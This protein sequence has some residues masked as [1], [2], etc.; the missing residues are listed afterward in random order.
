MS[1][2][3]P[4]S[5]WRRDRALV[6]P[7][8]KV[9]APQQIR[10]G[11]TVSLREGFMIP[12]LL[13]APAEE[14]RGA[15]VVLIASCAAR[16]LSVLLFFIVAAMPN[17]CMPVRLDAFVLSPS[18]C[19]L[20]NAVV[21]PIT[22]PNYGFL[23]YDNNLIQHDVLNHHD[24][25]APVGAAYNSRVTDL[26]TG[27]L[28][29][30]RL[31][32]YVHWVLPR[33]YRTGIAATSSAVGQQQEA[34][35]QQGFQPNKLTKDY[36]APDF[37]SAPNR[38][39]VIRR[40]EPGSTDNANSGIPEFQGWVLESDC[41]SSLEELSDDADLETD[42]S[43]FIQ[44]EATVAEQAEKFIGYREDA[45]TWFEG[46]PNP[47]TNKPPSRANL[48]L[49][50]SSNHLFAD[51]QPHNTNVFS[52]IDT[53]A[54]TTTDSKGNTVLQN[55]KWATASYY[56]LGWHAKDPSLPDIDPDPFNYQPTDNPVTFNDRMNACLMELAG[57]PGSNTVEDEW[58]ST[59]MG[60]DNLSRVVCHGAM[61]GV[62]WDVGS[63][64][65]TI[66]AADAAAKL[67]DNVA[68]GTTADDALKA[69]TT[70]KKPVSGQANTIHDIV[71]DLLK[72][73]TLTLAPEDTPDA[74]LE[75]EDLLYTANFTKAPGGIRYHFSG[76]TENTPQS[77]AQSNRRIG[78]YQVPGKPG[79][80]TQR[81]QPPAPVS[82]R[83]L[84]AAVLTP[85]EQLDQVN[86]Q[87]S[88]MDEYM[89]QARAL[90]W[91]IFAEWWKFASDPMDHNLQDNTYKQFCDGVRAKLNDY[92][93]QLRAIVGTSVTDPSQG[94]IYGLNNGPGGIQSTIAALKA[95]NPPLV[96]EAAAM[97]PFYL[98]NDPTLLIGGIPS[99]WPD[100]FG[101]QDSKV[102]NSQ[103]RLDSQI[104]TTMN[105][106]PPAAW[107]SWAGF[108]SK[109]LP[110]LPSAIK[111]TAQAL[112][113][114][115]F[116]LQLP[117]AAPTGDLPGPTGAGQLFPSFHDASGAGKTP[118]LDS[119]AQ[120]Q[121]WFPLF[122][123]WEVTYYHVSYEQWRLVETT[124][125]WGQRFPRYHINPKQTLRGPKK[126]TP[127]PYADDRRT[128]SGRIILLPQQ[129]F[130]TDAKVSQILR[131][132]NRDILPQDLHPGTQSR[133]ALFD[134][135]SKMPYLS[136]PLAGL[137]DN[138]LTRVNG[139]HIK[140]SNREPGGI[141]E[142]L[143]DALYRAT[144]I[145]LLAD[146]VEL[147]GIQ[148]N[149]TPYGSLVTLNNQQHCPF[150][151]VTH[152]Q[153]EFT[154]LNIVDKFGQVACALNPRPQ[155]A[156]APVEQ[157]CPFISDHYACDAV[158]MAGTHALLPDTVLPTN[159]VQNPFI[160]LPPSVNQ[161]SRLNNCFVVPNSTGTAW[162]VA[163][164][165]ENPIWGWIVINYADSA[166]QLFQADGTFYREV[167]VS[168]KRSAVSPPW[169]PL[170]APASPPDPQHVH[171]LD[172][173]ISR[174][175][176]PTDNFAYIHGMFDMINGSIGSMPALPTG[177]AGFLPGLIGKPLALA[178]LGI[179][180]ELASAPLGNESNSTKQL[181]D[182]PLIGNGSPS[183]PGYTFGVKIG[184]P[185]RSFDGL[186]GYYPSLDPTKNGGQI[187]LDLSQVFTYFPTDK[188]APIPPPPPPSGD[189]ITPPV[190]TGDPTT[191]IGPADYP[192]LAPYYVS[193]FPV[194]DA[195]TRTQAHAAQLRVF[196]ALLDPFVPVHF[197][198]A[199]LPVGELKL[200]A[201]TIES[202]M[203]RMTAFFHMGPLL[204]ATPQSIPAQCN[205]DKV[206]TD[207]YDL[208]DIDQFEIAD[209]TVNVPLPALNTADWAWLQPYAVPDSSTH[210]ALSTKY[211]ALPLG[212][213]DNKPRYEKTPYVAI[214]G[215]LQLTK[216][217]VEPDLGK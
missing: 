53:F 74:S 32:V 198:S 129:A 21:A 98:A 140:P 93:L 110:K 190:K 76:Q 197:Y 38:W 85:T 138:L 41:L 49:L 31:G 170:A 201:W 96:A 61:Y 202:A 184:D 84:Q 161:E 16:S 216:P 169:L 186:V 52:F 174:L 45:T 112:L 159:G 83:A 105:G 24:V 104:V 166:L 145:Q 10:D 127:Y 67:K 144:D 106:A 54:Y 97:G 152:G 124:S 26:G 29:P 205:L 183:S 34:K 69:Y 114:E 3:L 137:T 47:I 101:S 167:R 209:P 48:S 40:L 150:K 158:Q 207:K 215:Y 7:G 120:T 214:E 66:P 154:K 146:E 37:R 210:K 44:P 75:A 43:P 14:R 128:L 5:Q 171:Q 194:T 162:Q 35:K 155:P 8:S 195:P 51:Y 78:G 62:R 103:V 33:V 77:S 203:K 18:V 133:Q 39:M 57:K 199:I 30:N 63:A 2:S 15:S 211:N 134:D 92:L 206:L 91:L 187:G 141:P 12:S 151:P 121:A 42:V 72:I 115:F 11:L 113:G 143:P 60:A 46:R 149:K 56:V 125:Q 71:H 64:P 177:F 82:R 25:H 1:L 86:M 107:P 89:R 163:K 131:H 172:L 123:E 191:M 22:Q 217:I 90:Q 109:V 28:K 156:N 142:T 13:S 148:T 19:E 178:N 80:L 160:Q 182:R 176:D 6:S 87:Q 108:Q 102:K 179:S 185:V 73:S 100:G 212:R 79:R 208:T 136:S 23:R 88:A 95:L 99:P 27:D 122:I 164:E 180:L 68:I 189:P 139:T 168:D 117:P 165:R 55:L 118:G 65:P 153:M 59:T 9:V 147:M 204:V 193:C 192:Q 17:V 181:P 213:L 135:I 4:L 70:S 20:P 130:G 36:S 111:E 116:L 94:I 132:T 188:T 58:A 175:Q 119:F 157:L 196:G 81:A 50:T 200:P 126:G 173:L